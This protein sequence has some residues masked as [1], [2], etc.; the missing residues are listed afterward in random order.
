MLYVYGDICHKFAADSMLLGSFAATRKSNFQ[1]GFQVNLRK[2]IK[3]CIIELPNSHKRII[4][5]S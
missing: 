4:G 1:K 3:V 2:V 5:E